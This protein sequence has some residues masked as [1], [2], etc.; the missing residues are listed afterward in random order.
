VA[1]VLSFTK[2]GAAISY[3]VRLHHWFCYR[4]FWR[5]ALWRKASRDAELSRGD[6]DKEEE[7]VTVYSD[8]SCHTATGRGG[9]AA[10]LTCQGREKEIAG[11]VS[12]TTNN[13]ME[14]RAV[15]EGLKALKRGCDVTVVTDSQYVQKAFTEGWL[16]A[17]QKNGWRNANKKPLANRAL[18]EELL[19]HV[20]LHRVTWQWAKGH[21]GHAYNKRCDRLAKKQW[22]SL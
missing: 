21:A 10:I 8:G 11:G 9:Y 4:I 6:P 3:A 14:L 20:K 16:Q 1:R 18:W 15:L 22:Q 19:E 5:G 7:M 12:D 13:Q 2:Q 17:W